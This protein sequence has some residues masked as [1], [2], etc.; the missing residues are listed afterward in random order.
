MKKVNSVQ[1]DGLVESCRIV[2]E[3][4]G[5]TVAKLSVVTLH[6]NGSAGVASVPL[7]SQYDKFH[8]LVRVCA[9]GETAKALALLEKELR[10]ERA[11]GEVDLMSLHPCSVSG[12]LRFGP[13]G[14]ALVDVLDGGFSLTDRV[15]T[16][17]NNL[18]RITGNV[19]SVSFTDE[20]AR[21]QVGTDEGPVSVFFPK[22]LNRSGWDAVSA[23]KLSK[24]D[25]LTLSGPLVVSEYTDGKKDIRTCMLTPHAIHKHKLER[26]RSS[27]Q[28]F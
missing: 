14:D 1:L 26:K 7:S 16:R 2:G 28:S 23:G 20:S 9:S 12:V 10:T 24:G 27:G 17:D 5:R 19:L 18:V 8:H 3:L 21:L 22:S 11:A 13:D 25:M 4:S 6:P 15:K